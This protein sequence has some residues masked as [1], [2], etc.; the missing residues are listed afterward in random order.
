VTTKL[1]RMDYGMLVLAGGAAGGY[2]Q[3]VDDTGMQNL[4]YVHDNLFWADAGMSI[5]RP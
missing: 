1:R 4:T 2:Y 3:A 5:Q